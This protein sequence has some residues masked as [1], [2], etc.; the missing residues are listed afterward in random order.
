MY[1]RVRKEL[2]LSVKAFAQLIG[3]SIREV[4][5]WEAGI[6]EPDSETA[7]FISDVD[8]K[9]RVYKKIRDAAGS[10]GFSDKYTELL[11]DIR[12]KF[13]DHRPEK[14]VNLDVD[15]V[16]VNHLSFAIAD[17]FSEHGV[18][19]AEISKADLAK[20]IYEHIKFLF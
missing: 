12:R 15:E 9:I 6:G 11:G 14:L 20:H 13:E 4:E 2:G 18:G 16:L 7:R 3:A 17:Y 5:N 19:E 1:L 8:M 10:M